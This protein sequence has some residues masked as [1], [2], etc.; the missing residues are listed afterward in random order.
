V[1]ARIV[2]RGVNARDDSALGRFRAE[3]PGRNPGVTSLEPVGFAFPD[4]VAVCIDII[5]VPGTKTVEN[6]VH[7][8]G[9]VTARAWSSLCDRSGGTPP[10]HSLGLPCPRLGQFPVR[11]RPCHPGRAR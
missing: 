7:I 6:R 4:P 2:Q 8:P 3:A 1:V 9:Q 5:A 10:Q 11:L